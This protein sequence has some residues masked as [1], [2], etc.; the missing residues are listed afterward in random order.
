MD[1]AKKIGIIKWIL[2]AALV[3]GGAYFLVPILTTIVW[4]SIELAIGVGVGLALIYL[5]PAFCETLAS[6]GYRLWELAIRA[7]PLARLRRD[8]EAS[9]K[10]IE[11]YETDISNA[12]ASIDEVKS[13]VK[14]QAALISKEKMDDYQ[15]QLNFMVEAK[16]ELISRRDEMVAA[17]GEFSKA[18]EMADAEYKVGRSF[19]SAA[20]AF[21]FKSKTGSKSRGAQVAFEEVQKQ[22]SASH[23]KLQLA[24]SRPKLLTQPR[25]E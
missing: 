12:S 6:L 24:M 4:G 9:A 10:E 16:K 17:Y 2:L 11:N 15:E 3:L 19:S 7:D 13:V 18:I 1:N 20:K 14:K 22:L 8:Q 21:S 25:K 5:A 23:E